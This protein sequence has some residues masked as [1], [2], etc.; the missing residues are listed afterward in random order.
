MNARTYLTNDYERYVDSLTGLGWSL[1]LSMKI[2]NDRGK[3][4]VRQ[5]LKRHLPAALVDRE[6]QGFGQPIA[7]WLRGPLR[8]WAEELLD[9]KHFGEDSPFDSAEI[10]RRWQRH[11]RG[12]SHQIALWTA[13]M[14]QAWKKHYR[15]VM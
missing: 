10:R 7:E 15:A 3:W 6:K 11:L 8:P 2:R 9:P 13:L 4:I 14:F 5:L 1:P 12:E